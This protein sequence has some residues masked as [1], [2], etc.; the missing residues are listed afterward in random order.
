MAFISDISKRGIRPAQHHD[1]SWEIPVRI[2][3]YSARILGRDSFGNYQLD[4]ESVG[5][6]LCHTLWERGNRDISGWAAI[7]PSV[8]QRAT[9]PRGLASGSGPV[10][11]PSVASGNISVSGGRKPSCDFLSTS[12]MFVLPIYDG[13]TVPD[14]RFA[15]KRP[16]VPKDRAGQ[17]IFTKMPVGTVGLITSATYEY[18]QEDLFFPIEPRLFA[19]NM[20]GDADMGSLVCDLNEEFEVDK[21]RRARLQSMLWVLKKP[22]GGENALAWNIGFSG[23]QDTSGGFVIDDVGGNKVIAR[24]S[25]NQGGFL[26]VGTGGCKHKL[27]KDEDDHNVMS[28]HIS[29]KA[30]FRRNDVEDGPLHFEGLYVEPPKAPESTRVHLEWAGGVWKWRAESPIRLTPYTFDPKRTGPTKPSPANPVR[31]M[32]GD[33]P[34]T[35]PGDRPTAAD[36]SPGTPPQIVDVGDPSPLGP[37]ETFIPEEDEP[38]LEPDDPF[39]EAGN[40]I[41]ERRRRLRRTGVLPASSE[42]TPTVRPTG[43][44]DAAGNTL[45]SMSMA[46][47][48]SGLLAIPQNYATG[49]ADLRYDNSPSAADVAKV[50]NTTP[51]SGGLSSYGAQ[52]GVTATGGYGDE[53]VG[54]EHDPWGYTQRPGASRFRGGTAPGGWVFHPP[55][56]GPQDLDDYGMVPPSIAR[57]AAY[58]VA[59]PG[60]FFGAGTPELANGAL[61]DGFVW[62]ADESTFDLIFSSHSASAAAV[63][64][65]RFGRTSGNISWRSGTSFWG[66][67]DHANTVDRIYTFPDA[68]GTIPLGTGTANQVAYWSGTNALAGDAGLTYDAP[69]DVL[70]VT[71]GIILSALTASRLMASDGSK[72][73]VSVANLQSW[74]AGTSN[75]II[76]A[77]DGDGSITLSL[78]QNI[79]TGASPTF[80]GLTL[81]GLTDG[82]VVYTGTGGLLS[83][84]NAL[85]FNAAGATLRVGTTGLEGIFRV[86]ADD[87]A[88]YTQYGLDG[89]QQNASRPFLFGSN[90]AGVELAAAT[91]MLTFAALAVNPGTV[92]MAALTAVRTW[93][94]PDRSGTVLLDTTPLPPGPQGEPGQDGQDGAPGPAGAGGVPGSAGATGAQGPV[95]PAV[96]LEADPGEEGQPGP[97]G[98]GGPQ[99]AQGPQGATGAQGPLG[100]AVFFAAETGEEGQPGPPGAAGATGAQGPPGGADALKVF[101]TLAFR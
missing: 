31:P 14:L 84:A 22:V 97:R 51:V 66:E 92:T 38:G 94:F 3:E 21:D 78:P 79:H 47:G 96:F 77:D 35:A 62:G 34:T 40:R 101:S 5:D 88:K 70:T 12:N 75:Q 72:A 4:E 85:Q 48:V 30:L 33:A 60:A 69:T 11:G 95:G 15:P 49:M 100:P 63:T 6:E 59:G 54:G 67:L 74:I 57:S 7:W 82:R 27:G 36:G 43:I 32:P 46:L 10:L 2:V 71:G 39:D 56:T 52:G 50:V 24:V 8:V 19:V 99:G 26:D 61:R 29:T 93:T 25:V 42:S 1:N 90:V 23:C 81:T 18:A 37:G 83:V 76:T 86:Y 89:I 16:M 53:E 41:R 68:S 13:G 44:G 58:F 64:A 28:A 9:G 17:P 65:V 98:V 20:A 87:N 55:E 91:N 80:S 45:A 73:L